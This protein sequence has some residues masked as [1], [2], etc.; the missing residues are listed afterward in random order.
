MC[1]SLTH[2][3]EEYILEKQ[4]MII[5]SVGEHELKLIGDSC[6]EVLD[7]ELLENQKT[8]KTEL[9]NIRTAEVKLTKE[10]STEQQE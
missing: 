2:L 1:A 10:F 7:Y 4:G 9:I 8:L 5:A 3:V 6:A